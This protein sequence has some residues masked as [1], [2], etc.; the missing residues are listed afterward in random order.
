MTLILAAGNRD[1]MIFLADRRLSARGK[2][3]DDEAGK[4]GILT[5]GDA[6]LGFA[7]SG[8]ARAANFTTYPWLAHT[9]SKLGKPDFRAQEILLRLRS[10]LDEQFSA[11]HMSFVPRSALSLSV[12]FAG[13]LYLP[14]GPRLAWSLLSNVRDPINRVDYP[15]AVTKF[16]V[17]FGEG[18]YRAKEGPVLVYRLGNWPT[19]PPKGSGRLVGMLRERRPPHAFI[20]KATEMFRELADRSVAA[21]T[22]GKQISSLVIPADGGKKTQAEYHTA[23]NVTKVYFPAEVFAH[24]MLPG[25]AVG[26]LSITPV[27]K[28]GPAGVMATIPVHRNAPCPCGSGKKYRECHKKR[29]PRSVG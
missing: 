11:K 19:L 1:H 3:V 21:G 27:G 7:F 29:R 13:Y 4:A 10:K 24:P 8:L 2:A 12:L 26:E 25:L 14:T 5:C 15:L 17:G 16:F 9:L 20:G 23:R 28:S 22:I 6:R 18:D